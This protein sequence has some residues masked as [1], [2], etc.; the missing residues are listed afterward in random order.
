[1]S[2]NYINF[3][4]FNI[5]KDNVIFKID[6]KILNFILLIYLDKNRY[7]IFLNEFI[8]EFNGKIEK[9]ENLLNIIFNDKNYLINLLDNIVISY[10]NK[11]FLKKL[12]LNENDIYYIGFFDFLNML[13]FYIRW[14]KDIKMIICKINDF[15]I[16]DI[17]LYKLKID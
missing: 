14:N 2:L 8:Y 11:F 12:L 15:V 9:D 4:G 1:M 10:N 7:Y 13:N 5:F 17:I 3:N 16:K 6:G